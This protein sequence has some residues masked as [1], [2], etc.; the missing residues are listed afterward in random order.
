MTKCKECIYDSESSG[1]IK[2]QIENC[3]SPKCPLY[4]YRLKFLEKEKGH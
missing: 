3:T 2:Q 1:T 4:P